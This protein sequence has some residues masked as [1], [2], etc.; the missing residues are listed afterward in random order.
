MGI[1]I[2]TTPEPK[3][4]GNVRRRRKRKMIREFAVRVC[5]S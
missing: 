3:A 4:Q 1:S 2:K 5:V